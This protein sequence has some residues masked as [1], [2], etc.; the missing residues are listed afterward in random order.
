MRMADDSLH[1]YHNGAD[2]GR[3]VK[4]LPPVLYGVVD[5]YGTAEQVSITGEFLSVNRQ[6]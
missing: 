3:K 4:T 1:F 5:I 2:V 6:A